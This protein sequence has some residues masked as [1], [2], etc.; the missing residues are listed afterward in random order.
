MTLKPWEFRLLLQPAGFTDEQF[1]HQSLRVHQKA[2]IAT[3][4][5]GGKAW[6]SR[7]ARAAPS[8]LARH[9]LAPAAR[10][11]ASPQRFAVTSARTSARRRSPAA[12]GGRRRA[13]LRG[14]HRHVPHR[15]PQR[16][17]SARAER[18]RRKQLLTAL[19]QSPVL[20]TGLA[21]RGRFVCNCLLA[22]KDFLSFGNTC[23]KFGFGFLFVCLWVFKHFRF[24]LQE[25]KQP[26]AAQPRAPTSQRPQSGAARPPAYPHTPTA[27][28]ENE[29]P[30]GF[31]G[32]PPHTL[33]P[34]SE[35]PFT[36]QEKKPPGVTSALFPGVKQSTG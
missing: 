32:P 2:L 35:N 31:K 6:E 36:R 30:R 17:G 11:W 12:A 5:H 3:R 29:T 16:R 9:R 33:G 22:G 21:F 26:R 7:G 4:G 10:H 27:T 1:R 24:L 18:Q 13:A 19:L 34:L 23:V 20:Q 28:P 8:Q 15:E 25:D 14:W